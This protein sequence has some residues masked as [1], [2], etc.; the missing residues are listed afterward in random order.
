MEELDLKEIFNIFWKKKIQ[1]ILI[2]A[3][4]MVIGIIYSV[5][6]ITPMYASTTTLVLATSSAD[7]GTQST[8]G[9][10]TTDLTINTKLVSTYSEIIKSRNILRQVIDNLGINVSESNLR[11]N[12]TVTSVRNTE[13]I[14]IKVLNENAEYSAVLANEIAK[15]F[16]EK[17]SEIYNMNNVYLVDEAVSSKLP[18]NINHMK[19]IV[20]FI[21]AGAIISVLYVI[22]LNILDTTVKTQ[23]E[24]EKTFKIPVL[25]AIPLYET[26]TPKK[27]G[28]RR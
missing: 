10:T 4:F 27:K 5:G 17:V 11:N 24:I 28:G 21:M 18:S 26:R 9:I 7:K 12:I 19:N 13:L 6:F 22:L 25:A 14:E 23:E 8:E 16:T 15:V 20:I 3:I 1:I 2:I